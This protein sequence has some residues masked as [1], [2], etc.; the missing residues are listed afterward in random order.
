[1]QTIVR[2]PEKGKT[3]PA[4]TT[5]KP[6]LPLFLDPELQAEFDR[7]GFVILPLLGTAEVERLLEF[8]HSQDRGDA[9]TPPF[10]YSMDHPNSEY[11]RRVMHEL[12]EVVG[13]ALRPAMYDCQVVTASF[14]VKE[15]HPQGI[16]PPHQDWTF[17]DETRFRSATVWVPLVDVDFDNGA[18]GAI[19]GSHLFFPGQLRSSPSPQCKSLLSDHLWSIFP[20]LDVHP[21]RAGQAFIFDNATIH[22]SPPNV[23]SKPRIAAGIGVTRAEAGLQHTY[24]LPGTNPPQIETYSVERE[25]FTRYGN[26]ALSKLFEKGNHPDVTPIE[27]QPYMLEP[28]SAE[29]MT[30]L[31]KSNPQ[32]RCNERLARSLKDMF[33]NSAKQVP[34]TKPA[35]SSSSVDA[36]PLVLSDSQGTSVSKHGIGQFLFKKMHMLFGR[37]STNGNVKPKGSPQ[38]PAPNDNGASKG[39]DEAR[40]V[41]RFYDEQHD[42]FLKVYGN[43]IQ[44]FRTK[45][46][47]ELLNYQAE[48]IGLAP[49]MRVLDAGCGVAGPALHFAQHRGVE[50]DAI[51]IS[52]RQAEEAARRIKDAGMENRI[53]VR[54]ADYHTVAEIY[55]RDHFDAVYFLESFGHSHDKPALLKA[56]FQVLKPG[57]ILY[58]KDLFAKEPILSQHA[59]PIRREIEK[60]NAAYH[61]RIADLYDVL[62]SVRCLG[63]ILA[64][65]K[66]ID[67]ELSKFENLTISNDFQELTGIAKI[68]DWKKY[69]FPVEF[70]EMKC[71]KPWYD[72]GTG[73]SRYFLQNLYHLNVLGTRS[74]DL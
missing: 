59:E 32:N 28:I 2:N 73:N 74:G 34:I 14:V 19:H 67:L 12:I 41:G 46:V 6:H 16:V 22:G 68:E 3:S 24:L 27:R 7:E 70:Y 69:I 26:D 39:S 9:R 71:F 8:Y 5:S 42:A 30:G 18:L 51:T 25:F 60:I 23:T 40:A 15:A 66:T 37:K 72:P 21:L 53:R 33:E 20:Y 36:R 11:V 1:V 56:C 58:V 57:G 50:V 49:G 29:A 13:G 35:E 43:V 4:L 47:A 10:H 62:R 48:S 65:L 44:A 61:Y 55:P 63:Y 54:R 64:T 31:I 52:Q 45:D 17:V 38:R